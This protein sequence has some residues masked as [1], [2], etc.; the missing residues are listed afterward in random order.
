M[1]EPSFR[2]Y[3]QGQE[4]KIEFNKTPIGKENMNLKKEIKLIQN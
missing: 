2:E 3:I 4:S 1:I